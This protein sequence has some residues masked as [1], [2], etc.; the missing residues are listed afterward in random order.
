MEHME[1]QGIV[2]LIYG[3][4]KREGVEDKSDPKH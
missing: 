1:E 3:D 2:A 4:N